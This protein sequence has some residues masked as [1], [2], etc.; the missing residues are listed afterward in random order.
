MLY[1]LPVGVLS[2]EAFWGPEVPSEAPA[3]VAKLWNPPHRRVWPGA[4][5][6]SSG[7][8]LIYS[9]TSTD[10]VSTQSSVCP[11]RE[12]GQADEGTT[13]RGKEQE[14]RDPDQSTTEHKSQELGWE[15]QPSSPVLL[16]LKGLAPQSLPQDP[17]TLPNPSSTPGTLFG[18][19]SRAT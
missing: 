17:R 14:P 16:V 1:C 13:L 9:A 7:S 10:Q 19:K 3:S 18:W 8:L 12:S 5:L 4:R 11:Y 6:L 15:W 2:R